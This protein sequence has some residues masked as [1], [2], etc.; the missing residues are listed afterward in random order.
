MKR[1]GK[2]LLYLVLLLVWLAVMA[3]PIGAVTLA[4]NGQFTIN[5]TRVFLVQERTAVGIGMQTTR[6]A[7]NDATCTYNAVRYLMLRGEGE[8]AQS[9]SCSSTPPREARGGRCLLP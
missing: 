9:C 6:P 7:R 2:R 8:N 5:N 1:W 3:F 4:V